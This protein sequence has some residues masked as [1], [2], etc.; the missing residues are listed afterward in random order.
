MNFWEIKL[1]NVYRNGE[2]NKYENIKLFH[3]NR[4]REGER[5]RALGNNS[6]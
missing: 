2:K 6:K 4:N 3:I 1:Y 5:R